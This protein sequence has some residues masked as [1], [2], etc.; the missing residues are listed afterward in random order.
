[1][2]EYA[3]IS[4]ETSVEQAQW[5]VPIPVHIASSDA[6]PVR[7]VAPEYGT[8]MTWSVDTLANMGKPLQILT[9]RYR[10]YKAR[11]FVQSL[12][13]VGTAQTAQG[14]ATAPAANT[15]LCIIA[16]ASIVPGEYNI[17][18]NVALGGTPAAAETNNFQLRQGANTLATS[19]NPG[20]VGFFPQ[21]PFGPVFL[22]GTQGIA[23]R[24]GGTIGT[25]GA[26]YS[27]AVTITPVIPGTGTAILVVAQRQE[28]L[29]QPTPVG[30][31]IMAPI[32]F[33]WESQKPC[34]AVL[35]SASFGPIQVSTIDQAYEET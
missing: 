5:P 21:A 10:R 15:Q 12:A 16:A 34:Y 29:M 32:V 3:D 23:I 20:A 9:R 6:A 22:N 14:Q 13:P 19:D 30:S 31:T 27:A 33:D 28:L 17:S 1:M 24:T 18:W 4:Q 11:V 8:C 2:T 25:A 26:I 35:T 7:P